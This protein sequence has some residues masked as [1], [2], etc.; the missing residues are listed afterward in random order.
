MTIHEAERLINEWLKEEVSSTL[1]PYTEKL[2]DTGYW[3]LDGRF[4]VEKLA[5]KLSHSPRLV[6]ICTANK[7]RQSA[8]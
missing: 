7:E 8:D 2:C 1:I 4:N 3:I 5:K 6:A